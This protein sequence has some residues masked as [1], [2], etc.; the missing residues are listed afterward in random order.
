MLPTV[1][2]LVRELEAFPCWESPSEYA[3]SPPNSIAH[4]LQWNVALF[5]LGTMGASLR[6]RCHK[7]QT[8]SPASAQAMEI[9][10][11]TSE[12]QVAAGTSTLTEA[13]ASVEA[14]VSVGV[15]TAVEAPVSVRTGPSV[16]LVG[17]GDKRRQPKRRRRK[18]RE[19]VSRKRRYH[20]LT[21]SQN[22][23]PSR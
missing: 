10:S 4:L 14:S 5:L 9:D 13:P 11:P 20:W 22:F 2:S 1:T 18:R 15:S 19:G 3:A 7:C 6:D 21:L 8:S 17:R 16:L 12:V 23:R